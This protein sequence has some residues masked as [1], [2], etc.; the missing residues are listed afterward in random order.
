MLIH[1]D[2]LHGEFVALIDQLHSIDKF[3]YNYDPLQSQNRPVDEEAEELKE[4][5][6]D[7]ADDP[8]M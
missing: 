7:L 8:S 2:Y 6:K 3:Y 1:I 4:F 5:L